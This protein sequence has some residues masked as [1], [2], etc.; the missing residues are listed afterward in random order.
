MDLSPA[1]AT[2]SIKQERLRVRLL[3]HHLPLGV[4]SAVSAAALYFTRPY[5]DAISRASFATAYPALALLASTLLIGP[6]NLLRKQ[7][8]PVSN[9]LRRDLGIWAGI[10]GVLHA[11]VGQFVHLRGRPWL[12][13]VY[14]PTEHHHA[15]PLRHDLF[16]FSNYTGAVA[17]LLLIALLATSNDYSLRVL[18]TPR[19]K[20][21]QRWNYAVFALTACHAIGYLAIEK[22]KASFVAIVAVCLAISLIFQVAG[23]TRRAKR[24]AVRT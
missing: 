18:G 4:L 10:L 2:L 6:W 19:W 11:G 21:L 17:V 9:D 23:F 20:Q 24:S 14:G 5:S 15:I 16:G 1:V 12:Y 3:K 8:N 13:Y 7:T 22:Q